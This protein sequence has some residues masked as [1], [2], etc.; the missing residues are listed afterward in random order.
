MEIFPANSEDISAI[1]ELERSNYALE[2][3]PSGFLYQAL[4]QWPCG[5]LVAKVAGDVVGYALLGPAQTGG[6]YW[7]MAV[8]VSPH[9]RGKGI[10]ERLC[11]ASIQA[12]AKKSG[13]KL[14]LSVAPNNKAALT[15]YEKLGFTVIRSDRHFLGPNQ[16]RLI[17]QKQLA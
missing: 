13:S 15:L 14:W 11:L 9:H 10:G 12:C 16:E 5:L 17:L 8:L 3:Y 2:A 4:A 7:L 6:E 1:T